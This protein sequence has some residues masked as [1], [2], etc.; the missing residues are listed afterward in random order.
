MTKEE[1]LAKARQARRR[2]ATTA[3]LA[4]ARKRETFP[5]TAPLQDQGLSQSIT[6]PPA[7]AQASEAAEA[8]AEAEAEATAE[9]ADL[10]EAPAN[11]SRSIRESIKAI[12][13][14]SPTPT[15]E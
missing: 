12:F 7:S 6:A 5:V 13:R 8:E 3:L 10:A 14:R 2:L 1:D 15:L 11:A 4:R 9:A